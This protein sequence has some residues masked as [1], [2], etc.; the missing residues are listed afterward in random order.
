[1]ETME[2]LHGKDSGGRI[3]S[4]AQYDRPYTLGIRH[5]VAALPRATASLLR[6]ALN[7]WIARN[8]HGVLFEFPEE[9][10]VPGG[11]SGMQG[12]PAEEQGVAD[13]PTVEGSD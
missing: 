4:G 13:D 12:N 10:R 11:F 1:M 8:W 2:N 5:R 3:N 7:T 9:N 6:H